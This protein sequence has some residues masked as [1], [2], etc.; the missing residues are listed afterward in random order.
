VEIAKKCIFLFSKFFSYLAVSSNSC[1]ETQLL[2]VFN[3]VLWTEK[4]VDFFYKNR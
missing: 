2:S 3:A 4:N 1:T